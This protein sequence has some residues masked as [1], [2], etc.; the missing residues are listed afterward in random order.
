M[1]FFSNLYYDIKSTDNQDEV[2]LTYDPKTPLA[3]MTPDWYANGTHI[4][5]IIFG[6]ESCK[7]ECAIS[8]ERSNYQNITIQSQN[9]AKK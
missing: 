2:A 3:K 5:N 4:L 7:T 9:L 1:Q 8:P 6:A